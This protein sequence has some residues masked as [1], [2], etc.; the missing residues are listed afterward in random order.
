VN[1]SNNF[2]TIYVNGIECTSEAQARAE[3]LKA[4]PQRRATDLKVV[5]REAIERE[6]MERMRVTALLKIEGDLSQLTT[7]WHDERRTSLMLDG[8]T[9]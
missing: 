6:V 1:A 3:M 9:R 7:R 8:E 5:Q 4:R 2:V